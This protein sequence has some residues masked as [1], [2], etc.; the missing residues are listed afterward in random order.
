MRLIGFCH[1][2]THKIHNPYSKENIDLFKECGCN[3]IEVS[4]HSVE[5]ANKLSS[6]LPFIESFEYVSLHIPGDLKYKNDSQTND[7]LKKIET[8]YNESGAKL[9]VVHPD[10]VED[11]SVFDNYPSVNWAIE[12]M[13]DRKEK[14]RDVK[15]LNEFFT[16][17]QQ[18]SFVL[19]LGHC[20]ANDKSMVLA[21]NLIRELRNK[22][23][24]IHLSGNEVIHDPLHR[25]KQ[26]EIIKYCKELDVPIIIESTFEKSDGVDG[27]AKEFN[28]I[29]ENLK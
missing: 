10:L 17:Y 13:D 2:A 1:R 12:N 24:E 19:D 23:K 7:L 15:D 26:V 9:A 3:A 21:E 18:W 27:V 6:I 4:C 28:Y 29:L 14:Y 8:F 11:W 5:E 22:I 25:T 16:E 20:N